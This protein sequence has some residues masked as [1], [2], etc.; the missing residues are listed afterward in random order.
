MEWNG[1]VESTCCLLG[2]YYNY[3]PPV[4][5]DPVSSKLNNKLVVT[6]LGCMTTVNIWKETIVYDELTINECQKKDSKYVQI[7]ATKCLIERIIAGRVVDKFK[8]L[9]EKNYYPVCLFPT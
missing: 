2:I 1:L 8:E 5:G 9:C 7:L 3:V 4:T 6:R